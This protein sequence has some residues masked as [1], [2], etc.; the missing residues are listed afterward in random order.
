MMSND[1]IPRNHDAF[2]VWFRRLCEYVTAKTTAVPPNTAPEWTHIPP[3][4][5]ALLNDAYAAWY[6]AYAPTLGPHTPAETLARDEARAAAEAVIRPFVGQWLMWKQ[7]SDKERE[8][9]GL[10]NKKRRRPKIPAPAT[11]PELTPMPGVPRQLLIAYHDKG[12]VR[13]GKPADIHSIEIRWAFM[14]EPPGKSIEEEL[15]RSSSGTNSPLELTFEERDRGR[16]LYLAGRWKISREEV[17]GEF[18]DIVTAIVP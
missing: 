2:D 7:V 16:R 11:V 13:R 9:A 12:S 6:A 5:V 8:E 3:P 14:N 17:K 1:Y 4:E 18:G 10:R 15:T